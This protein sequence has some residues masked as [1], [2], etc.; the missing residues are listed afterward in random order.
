SAQNI[1]DCAS[2]GRTP[3]QF[4][5]NFATEWL[6]GPKFLSLA[7]SEWPRQSE[8]TILMDE[9]PETRNVHIA[10]NVGE[11]EDHFEKTLRKSSSLTRLQ[12]VFAYVRRFIQRCKQPQNRR[13]GPL[14]SV[15]LKE[16]L[17]SI[18]FVTQQ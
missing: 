9:L 4:Y 16:A 13:S 10:L 11:D 17:Q 3:Q 1:A 12:R 8:N 15:E 18:V 2:R 14:S 6:C 5:S 7:P